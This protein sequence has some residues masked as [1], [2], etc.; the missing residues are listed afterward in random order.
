MT[1]FLT[2]VT[3]AIAIVGARPPKVT[4]YANCISVSFRNGDGQKVLVTFDHKAPADVIKQK[5][6]AA[7]KIKAG[8]LAS[9]DKIAS[10]LGDTTPRKNIQEYQEAKKAK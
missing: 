1:T 4:V 8:N 3:D 7:Y 10:I 6:A 9:D 5:I 2:L